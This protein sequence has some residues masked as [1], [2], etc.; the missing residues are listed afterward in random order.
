MFKLRYLINDFAQAI[1]KLHLLELESA[2]TGFVGDKHQGRMQD[3][4]ERCPH[5]HLSEVPKHCVV[6]FEEVILEA[7]PETC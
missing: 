1:S 6:R 4:L 5:C 3:L 7:L 2:T